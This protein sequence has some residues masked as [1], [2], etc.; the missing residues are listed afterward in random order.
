MSRSLATIGVLIAA[1]WAGWTACGCG[2]DAA[3]GTG[4]GSDPPVRNLDIVT[5]FPF[6]S[7][8]SFWNDPPASNANLDP[9]STKLIGALGAEVERELEVGNGPWINTIDYSVPIYTVPPDQPTVRVQLVS[10]FYAPALQAAW[11]KVPMPPGARPAGGSDRT[12]VV[13]QPSTERLWEFWKLA[14]TTTGWRAAWGGAMQNVSSNWGAYGPAAWDGAK[15]TWGTSA[16]SL[17]IA[18][19]LITLKDLQRGQIDHAL[20]L[21]VPN[22]RAGIYASPARRTDGTS[23][24]PTSLPEGAHLRLDPSLNIA[25][26]ELPWLTSLIAK[27]AKRYG[28]FV[29]DKA[30]VAHFFAQDPRPTGSNPYT[31]EAGYFEGESPAQ[32]LSSFPWD[33]LQLLRME[34]HTFNPLN[35]SGRPK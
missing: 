31:G 27:A 35:S 23:A 13:W 2:S 4:A 14:H 8:T 18:G 28:I 24:S 21:A 29:R 1:L 10:E 25:A 17:S 33:R 5:P 34:L 15:S 32:L 30:K 3:L 6:F 22:T 19:G 12:L 7:P 11:N 26:L 16:S 20:A 9:N